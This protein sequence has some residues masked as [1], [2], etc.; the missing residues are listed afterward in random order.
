MFVI[1]V[2]TGG[3]GTEIA[4]GEVNRFVIVGGT[5]GAGTGTTGVTWNRLEGSA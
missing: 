2:G 3:A 4:G 5:G 1:G